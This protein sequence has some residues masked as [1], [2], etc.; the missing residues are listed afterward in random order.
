MRS[1]YRYYRPMMPMNPKTPNH[2][3]FIPGARG[4]TFKVIVDDEGSNMTVFWAL[5]SKK[6][7]FNKQ[8]GRQLVDERHLNEDQIHSFGTQFRR[9]VPIIKQLISALTT[10]TEDP[11]VHAV[12]DDEIYSTYC[13][14]LD[15]LKATYVINEYEQDKRKHFINAVQNNGAP[16][17]HQEAVVGQTAMLLSFYDTI[18]NR[19]DQFFKGFTGAA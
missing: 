15:S 10:A 13:D 4:V 17:P 7:E 1:F 5:Q 8:T 19:P 11:E 9:D 6:D 18:V 12:L 2:K 16:I 3:Q 14:L